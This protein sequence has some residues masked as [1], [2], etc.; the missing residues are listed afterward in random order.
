MSNEKKISVII[1]ARNESG[2]L[3][4]MLAELPQDLLH[5]IIVVDGNS[6]D[7]TAE[8]VRD[9]GFKVIVQEGK[10]YG[11]AVATGTPYGFCR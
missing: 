11:M 10:G 2:S 3:P 9:L 7:G 4:S 8:L 6:T 5:E 1:P